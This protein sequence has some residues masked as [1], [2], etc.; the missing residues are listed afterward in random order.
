MDYR[1]NAEGLWADR[2]GGDTRPHWLL[3]AVRPFALFVRG[4][5]CLFER[6]RAAHPA[7]RVE[8]V[9]LI[10]QPLEQFAANDPTLNGC[11]ISDLID[12]KAVEA[13][14]LMARAFEANQVDLSV[15]GDWE[16]VQVE[17]GLLA[18]RETPRRNSWLEN[19]VGLPPETADAVATIDRSSPPRRKSSV[20]G[21]ESQSQT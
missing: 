3:R 14:P 17:L 11:L 8:C 6:N 13:A 19:L 16:D 2:L 18:Q 10:V 12:L 4:R 7:V 9:S 21:Q 5:R 15:A 1:G 20:C